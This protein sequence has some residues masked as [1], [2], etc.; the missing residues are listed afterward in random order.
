MCHYTIGEIFLGITVFGTVRIHCFYLCAVVLQC[1]Q[2]LVL[3][4]Q[5]LVTADFVVSSLQ[6]GLVANLLFAIA[7]F[8]F[9]TGAE[10]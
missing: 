3:T 8:L 5:R 10:K 2:Q 4:Y 9:F 6:Y 7:Q 1:Q